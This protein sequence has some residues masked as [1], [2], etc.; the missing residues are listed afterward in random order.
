[1]FYAHVGSHDWNPGKYS[2]AISEGVGSL[3]VDLFIVAV[4]ITAFS[5]IIY[6]SNTSLRDFR[7]DLFGLIRTSLKSSLISFSMRGMSDS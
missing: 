6:H 2:L 3:Q 5:T 7:V 1:M 4:T